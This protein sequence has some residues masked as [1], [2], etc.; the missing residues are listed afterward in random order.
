MSNLDLVKSI[1]WDVYRKASLGYVEI[2]DLI[3]L[4]VVGLLESIS[5]FDPAAETSFAGFASKRIRG[6]MLNGL[7]KQSEYHAQSAFRRRI[8]RERL[9]S[10]AKFGGAADG[11]SDVFMQ[12]VETALG[13][14][15]GYLLED[16]TMYVDENR[17]VGQSYASAG[18]MA[19]VSESLKSLVS[20]LPEPDRQIVEL[21]YFGAVQ[22]SDIAEMMR[23]TKGR[24]S[25]IHARALKVLRKLQS[26]KIGFNLDV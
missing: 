12:M 16:T 26:G 3:Q 11:P 15:V 2:R 1:A 14:A 8:R 6:A 25:Q 23:L 9:E 24:V 7:E 13:L 19:A 5:R 21:H 18:E 22:F 10:L 4:G 20:M 17:S